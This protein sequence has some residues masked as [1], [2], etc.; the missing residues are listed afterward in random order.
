AVLRT[1]LLL[2]LT[3]R[4]GVRLVVIEAGAGF[5]KT[6]L[7]AHA[8]AENR[9][10]PVGEDAWLSC[11]NADASESHLLAAL[12]S[13]LGA[14]PDVAA[15]PTVDAV[16]EAMWAHA[17][18]EVCLVLD[19]VHRIDPA[20]SGWKALAALVERAPANGHV[21]LAGRTLGP[22]PRHQLLAKR[23][24]IALSEDELRLQAEE[25]RAVAV[26]HGV[27]PVALDGAA[28]WPALAEL[29]ARA[30]GVADD[31]ALLEEVLSALPQP[32]RRQFALVVA[33]GGGDADLLTA[34]LGEPPDAR[35]LSALPL[36]RPVG[37]GGLEPHALWQRVL[38]AELTPD[39]I[40]DARRRAAIACAD[41]GDNRTAFELLAAARD[42][43]AALP[44]LFDA[45]HDQ[46][47]PPWPE[48][49]VRWRTM[50]PAELSDRPEAVYL[51]G[52][53]ERAADP[54]S[55]RGR[56]A[57]LRVN[58]QFRA[59]GDVRREFQARLRAGFGAWLAGDR[60][61][62]TANNRRLAEL[63]GDAVP[64]FDVLRRFNDGILADLDLDPDGALDAL[65]GEPRLE[66]RLDFF[67]PL[68]RGWAHLAAGDGP[69]A[70]AE[71]ADALEKAGLS[72]GA[73]GTHLCALLEVAG[74]WVSGDLDAA[75]ATRVADPGPRWSIAERVPS[76]AVAAIIRAHIGSVD[77]A[78]ELL[79]HARDLVR[80]VGDRELLAGFLAVAEASILVASGDEPS[81]RVV[82][83]S[84]MDRPEFDGGTTG[85]ALAWF[86]AALSSTSP[87]AATFVEGLP[88]GPSRERAL[89]AVHALQRVRAGDSPG[90]IA[91]LDDGR[92]LLT[93]LPVN[94]ASEVACGAAADGDDRGRTV[95]E[96]L[97]SIAPRATRE[98]LQHVAASDRPN[99]ARRAASAFL[100]DIP[101]PP[102]DGIGVE[103]FGPV[104]LVRGGELVTDRH[105]RRER[106]R[107]LLLM[108]V[109][110]RALRRA[111]AAD[112]LWPELDAEASSSNLRT[113]LSYLLG[114][115]EPHRRQGEA[116][117]LLAQDAGILRVTDD[118][119][120]IVDAW[121][122][123]R[124][125]DAAAAAEDSGLVS[126]ALERLLDALVLW[127]GPYLDDVATESWAQPARRRA[128]ERVA[129]AAIRASELLVAGDRPHEAARPA[130]IALEA[131]PWSESAYRTLIAA[132]LA[133]A[134]RGAATQAVAECESM[135]SELGVEPDASTRALLALVALVDG[136]G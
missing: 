36:V 112:L 19:D 45:S 115:L 54:W 116:P 15:Q 114:I 95:V 12:M 87:T 72:L 90:D 80:D 92:A 96:T 77:E 8:V 82:V 103:V 62:F 91:L 52:L 44:V 74:A 46:L 18:K 17:P 130:R 23:D 102:P 70:R 128:H 63:G 136:P 132:H 13:A 14:E 57:F 59:K 43:E 51:D 133:S 89:G 134:D 69:A 118:E 84:L 7:L 104:R 22:M 26:I 27:D 79:A 97:R 83:S 71:A 47:D 21:V 35:T 68:G 9:L 28:G 40:L 42:W 122:L 58:D 55:A 25:I 33:V 48:T 81:A 109:D 53:V 98:A 66:P 11:D 99:P 100:G 75:T 6:T 107:H 117:Y 39:E 50:I 49:L 73:A 2:P 24:A 56:D 10:R 111:E 105:W 29:R 127:H 4:F 76:L 20:S 60:E 106:V 32:T 125:L 85:R 113:T 119:H 129:R 30:R 5:G 34:A 3:R 88:A 110:R 64:G 108:L 120:F 124:L 16:C 94:L 67:F 126:V 135:L 1:R 121:E 78:R 65:A 61:N 86:G 37:S 31:D 101:I 123:E 93:A 131:D 38:D 41:K